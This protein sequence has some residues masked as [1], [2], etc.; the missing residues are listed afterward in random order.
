MKKRIL[1]FALVLLF[2]F[3]MIGTVDL[4]G[5][6]SHVHADDGTGTYETLSVVPGMTTDTSITI[7]AVSDKYIVKLYKE[8][9]EIADSVTGPNISHP[10]HEGIKYTTFSGLESGTEYKLVLILVADNTQKSETSAS[11]LNPA[12]GQPSAPEVMSRSSRAI[13]IKTIKGYQYAISE[14]A[15]VGAW[16]ATQTADGTYIFSGLTAGKTYYIFARVAKGASM[17]SPASNPTIVETVKVP[18]DATFVSITNNSFTINVIDGVLYSIDGSNYSSVTTFN[19]TP[20]APVTLYS[21]YAATP[22]SAEG[23][24]H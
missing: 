3:S 8:T 12:S 9:T 11:T 22:T 13:K 7:Y 1:S 18:E 14:S 10:N 15:S 6:H 20:G 23:D 21:K 19:A 17:E 16:G 4:T 24:V 5:E 2:C